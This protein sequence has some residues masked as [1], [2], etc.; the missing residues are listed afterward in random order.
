MNRRYFLIALAVMLPI[1]V[2]VPAKI[3]AS[4]RPI[5]LARDARFAV[6]SLQLRSGETALLVG[7][8]TQDE[9]PLRLDLATGAFGV[10]QG[11]GFTDDGAAQW[12]WIKSAGPQIEVERDG[13]THVYDV[14]A[15][16]TVVASRAVQIH[17]G[18]ERVEFL[19][20]QRYLRWNKGASPPVR[21]VTFGGS[22]WDNVALTRDGKTMVSAA[23]QRILLYS[24]RDGHVL[25]RHSVIDKNADYQEAAW[26]SRFG[27]YAAYQT[28]TRNSDVVRCDVFE[29][30]SGRKLW[31][32][33]HDKAEAI[34]LCPDEKTLA[35]ERPLEGVWRVL[36]LRSGQL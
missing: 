36:D 2:F 30:A 23:P 1:A 13:E 15:D 19:S 26:V 6:R 24:T 4:W 17:D 29:T 14:P 34:V 31:S 9:R 32:F 5:L 20:F 7:S 3:A 8:A 28:F 11:E 12:R 18:P 35:H 16:V 27:K 25:Q 21:D 10:S 33:R 22:Y